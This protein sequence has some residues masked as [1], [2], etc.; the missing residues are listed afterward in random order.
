MTTTPM[1]AAYSGF[2]A[3]V[4]A[5][6]VDS[7][8]LSSAELLRVDPASPIEIDEDAAGFR[9]AV[10]LNLG[11]AGVRPLMGSGSVRWIVERQVRVELAVNDPS[12][13]GLAAMLEAGSN[14]IAGLIGA[15]ADLTLGGLVERL[16]VTSSEVEDLPPSGQKI[17]FSFVL[18]L[19]AGDPVGLTP[20]S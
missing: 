1:E 20:V 10:V 15:G 16:A 2:A 19:S 9:A 6:L 11:T 12:G 4:A 14:A 13:A 17:F 8:F 7:G 3:L 18:R 5:A